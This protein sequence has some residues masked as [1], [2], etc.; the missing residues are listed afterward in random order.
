MLAWLLLKKKITHWAV[1]KYFQE[2]G[3]PLQ[4]GKN[5]DILFESYSRSHLFLPISDA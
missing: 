1:Q 2:Y 5:V 4:L 3:F